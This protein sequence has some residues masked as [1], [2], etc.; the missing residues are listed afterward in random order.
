MAELRVGAHSSALQ[1]L[2]IRIYRYTHTLMD[3][4]FAVMKLAITDEPQE[5]CPFQETEK[6]LSYT[7]R[8]KKLEILNG[9]PAAWKN[10][11]FKGYENR[12]VSKPN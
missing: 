12:K 1:G 8:M 2:S 7:M 10:N 11:L 5:E 6:R 4:P 9:L 3:T